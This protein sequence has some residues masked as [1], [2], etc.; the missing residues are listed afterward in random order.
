MYFCVLILILFVIYWI[1]K[2]R[3]LIKL[4]VPEALEYP[5]GMRQ[6]FSLYKLSICNP[7]GI[8]N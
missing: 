7:E 5:M 4:N 6:I 3:K 2:N 8:F 1:I